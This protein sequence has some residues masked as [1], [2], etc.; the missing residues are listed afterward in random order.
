MLC[1]VDGTLVDASGAVH[2]DVRAAASRAIAAGVDI[3]YATGR[4]GGG[5][6][7]LQ[8]QLGLPGPHV[9]ANGGQVRMDGR[10]VHSQ[11][12]DA[13]VVDAVR[14]LQG[15]YAEY[16][17]DEGFW[18]TDLRAAA[19]PHWD[20]LG[21]EPLGTVGDVQFGDVVKITVI[22]F[23]EAADADT[24]EH[25]HGLPA[26]VGEG[27]S[28]ATP[29]LEYINL[30]HP[31]ADK[32]TALRAAARALGVDVAATVAV[33]DERNDR[34]MLEVAGTAIAMGQAGPEVTRAAHLLAPDV[35]RQGLVAVFDAVVRWAEQT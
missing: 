4:G 34:P 13:E 31:E 16:Y 14:D 20:L 18:A 27:T 25:L 5:L 21:E 2:A 32:G 19:R 15:V 24:L 33:G 29:G 9:I 22:L 8:E 23:G 26:A 12:L 35:E 7:R 10:A 6:R 1:D 11:P 28:P 3:G 30:T 17:T